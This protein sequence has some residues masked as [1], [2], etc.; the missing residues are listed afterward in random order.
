MGSALEQMLQ[1]LQQRATAP[2]PLSSRTACIHQ[3]DEILTIAYKA[4]LR[5][6]IENSDLY[7]LP[8]S[9]AQVCLSEP[10]SSRPKLLRLLVSA[11]EF[12]ERIV[13]ERSS[14][15]GTAVDDE[16]QIDYGAAGQ[17]KQEKETQ[18]E[19]KDFM[20]EIADYALAMHQERMAYLQR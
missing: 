5:S 17:D 7:G 8:A 20:A 13:Q 6:R 18:K 14:D 10:W 3:V 19:L 2:T 16:E 4:L 12:T 15:L 11:F 1:P 9:D